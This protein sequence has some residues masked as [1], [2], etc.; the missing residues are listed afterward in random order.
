MPEICPQCGKEFAN[1]KALGSHIHYVHTKRTWVDAVKQQERSNSD[2][3]I[4]QNLLDSCLSDT[5]LPKISDMEQVEKA[6]VEIPP[7]VSPTL[8]KYRNVFRCAH[9]KEQLL[10]KVEKLLGEAETEDIK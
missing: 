10:K 3:K 8:D 4:F 2:K 5:D 1:S 9:G 7:G 6:I